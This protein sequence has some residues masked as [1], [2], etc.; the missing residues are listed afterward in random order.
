MGNGG[1]GGMMGMG[2]GQCN[3]M[4]LPVGHAIGTVWWA[5][6][7]DSKKGMMRTVMG[8]S[9]G[10]HRATRRQLMTR[11]RLKS[12]QRGKTR[13]R[14]GL[15][16]LSRVLLKHPWPITAGSCQ[17]PFHRWESVYSPVLPALSFEFLRCGPHQEVQRNST[18]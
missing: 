14:A 17:I 3:G 2:L 10:K 5:Y 11:E 4:E 8:Y 16:A 12:R 7:G 15:Q 6:D 9:G 18:M 13:G 1:A